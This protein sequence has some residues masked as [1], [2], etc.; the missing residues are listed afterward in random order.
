MKKYISY[1]N[2]FPHTSTARYNVAAWQESST[3]NL[4]LIGRNVTKAGGKN[5]P[6]IGSLM[7]SEF[8]REG[9]LIAE[10]EVW[11]PSS[12]NFSLEDPRAIVGQDGIITIGLTAVFFSNGEVETYPALVKVDSN[13]KK[14]LPTVTVIKD[15]GQGKNMTPLGHDFFVFR[16]SEQKYNHK[17]LMFKI[18]EE[19]AEKITDLIFS[20]ELPWAEW[21]IGTAMPPIWQKDGS[22][23]FFIHGI[24]IEEGKYIYSIGLSKIFP[25]NGTYVTAV[26]PEPILTP[27]TFTDGEG[28]ALIEELRPEERKV[29]YACG[30]IIDQKNPEHLKLYVNVGDRATFE[31]VFEMKE[32]L[33]ELNNSNLVFAEDN[34]K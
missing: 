16:P 32:I 26:C 4:T 19:R 7:L 9:Q 23:I 22:A 11:K 34:N 17:L 6:D 25:K 33:N 21:R 31:V 15:F 2:I 14:K 8:D 1:K 24:S 29:V 5:E 10:H 18:G 20:K 28:K 3:G 30:G 12:E 27:K 13:W